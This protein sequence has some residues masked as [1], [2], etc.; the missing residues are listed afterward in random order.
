MDIKGILFDFDGTLTL[1]GAINFLEIKDVLG[2]A[3]DVPILEFIESLDEDEQ[4]NA[5]NFLD[6]YEEKAARISLP[7]PGAEVLIGELK[8][9]DLPLGI[10][11]RNSL[12]AVL[13]A[14]N[15]FDTVR[16]DDFTIILTRDDGAPK[17]DPA[18]VV[19]A[20]KKMGILTEELLLV[21]DFSLDII[22]GHAAG[23]KTALVVHDANRIIP[24]H[25]EPD[26]KIDHLNELISIVRPFNSK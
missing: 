21:G 2:C 12:N 11:T 25:P 14:L 17:P 7:A 1:P 16:A 18:G 26:Y 10:I 3:P 22:A 19:M 4:Q 9:R 15:N 6:S 5:Y 8:K 20:A 24:P 23:A 13:L